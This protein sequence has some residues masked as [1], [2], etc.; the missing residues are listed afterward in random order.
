MKHQGLANGHRYQARPCTP[1]LGDLP[2]IALST[3]SSQSGTAVLPRRTR[4]QSPRPRQ[5]GGRSR[6][7]KASPAKRSKVPQLGGKRT[8][9]P[10]K[11]AVSK[12]VPQRAP[13]YNGDS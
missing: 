13:L 6:H 2:G 10:S 11:R 8:Q 9:Q 12:R 5:G 3:E 7:V 4:R 1:G